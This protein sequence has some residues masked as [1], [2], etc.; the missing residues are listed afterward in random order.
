K[1][2][3]L[4]S[5]DKDMQNFI[6]MEHGDTPVAMPGED[7]V[8]LSAGVA[9]NLGIRQGDAVVLRNADLDSMELTVSGI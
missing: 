9:E 7:Q 3:Y 6:T 5:G 2:I 8:V 1:E 4:L